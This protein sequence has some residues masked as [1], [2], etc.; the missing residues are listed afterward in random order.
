MSR[1]EE[2]FNDHAIHDT[3]KWLRE[4]V[5]TN[6][7][8]LDDSEVIEKRRFLKLL[9]KYEEILQGLDPELIP[10]A[11]L[12][13]FNT[14]LRNNQFTPKINAYKEKG[15]VANLTEA[16]NLFTNQLTTLSIF[17]NIGTGE[18]ST[19]Q[20]QDLEG[21]I[22]S[23][24][25]T[26]I[27]KKNSLLEN[28]KEL[29]ESLEEKEKRLIELSAHIDQKKSEVDTHVSEWQN[30]FSTAQ[31]SRSQSFSQWR[32]EFSNERSMEI[33]EEIDG[34]KTKL[35]ESSLTFEEKINNILS[36]G[37][38]KHQLILELY[39][40][41]ADDSVGASF[42]KNAK[43]E[44][45]QA[46]NWR[47]ISIGFILATVTWMLFA[48][49]ISTQP[50]M[51]SNITTNEIQHKVGEV[52]VAKLKENPKKEINAIEYIPW[53]KLFITFSLS[54]VLL[55]GSAYSAQQSTK[56]RKNEKKAR[57]FALEVRAIDPF[58]STLEEKDRNELKKQ[59]S[60]KIFGQL[61]ATEDESSV[62][63]EHAFKMITDAFG[64]IISKV[65]K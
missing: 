20:F 14:F 18:P 60:Q 6:F 9:S 12:D 7:D 55:W 50:S 27:D 42:L 46:D 54:G 26:L 15:D 37:E 59:F 28:I 23:T 53:Y 65:S 24:S 13:S 30:Q 5:S 4:S 34:Y 47:R 36:D 25:Q 21:L 52:E 63:D 33:T 8:D 43:D 61:S 51:K 1:W 39:Q 16:N 31:D 17:S 35:A 11:Q 3:F 45:K 62:I 48:Y 58:I 40:I 22:D 38:E 49:S 56:H 29:T 57:W 19:N 32:D 41:T 10:F 2:Q 44:K 64:S